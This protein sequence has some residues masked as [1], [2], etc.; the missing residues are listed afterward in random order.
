MESAQVFG[1]VESKSVITFSKFKMADPIWRT[2]IRKTREKFDES[3][4][5]YVYG[6]AESESVVRF[7]ISKISNPL[8]R[9]EW[10]KRSGT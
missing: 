6:V 5:Y 2:E 3:V 9:L 1:V 10:L 8:W 4:H 7:L